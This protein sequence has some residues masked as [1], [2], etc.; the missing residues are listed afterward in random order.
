M[1]AV[2]FDW[3]GTLIDSEPNYSLADER[4]LAR[5]GIPYSPEDKRR[6]IGGGSLDMM[7][8]VK[9]R[10]GLAEPPEQLVRERGE[11][12]LRLAL[13]KTE[14]YPKMKSFLDRIKA[15][16]LPVAVA[17]GSA[18]VALSRLS[19]KLGLNGVFDAVVSA[20]EVRLAKPAPDVFLE[21]AR[22]LG[23]EAGDCVVVEDSRYG[24]EAALAAGM[25]CIAVPYLTD[26]PLAEAFGR[27]D[28]LF[29]GGMKTFSAE[30][31]Y[32]WIERLSL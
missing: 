9:R 18:P 17:S 10:F 7:I 20:E 27:A 13:E 28:L 22:R 21:A 26:P 31:A 8:D 16:G 30:Q 2:I 1:R 25:R 15:R 3:D 14:L 6:Y 11:L 24:V 4:F 12:Y 5:Y 19:A 29:P 32:A 23:R